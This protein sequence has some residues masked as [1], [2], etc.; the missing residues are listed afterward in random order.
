MKHLFLLI[1]FII[2]VACGAEQPVAV[3]CDTAACQSAEF[4]TLG[5]PNAP[6][7]LIE[8][9]DYQC[10]FCERHALETFP[11][12]KSEL[13]DTGRIRYQL[14]D[15]PI[16]ALHPLA[17]RQHAAARCVGAAGGTEAYWT[18]HDLFFAEKVRFAVADL[19]A[20][21]DVILDAFAA[22]DLPN[23]SD[24]LTSGQ[25]AADVQAD[26]ALGLA[27]EV[28]ATPTFEIDGYTFSG[29]QPFRVFV[30]LVDAAENGQLADAF[31][32]TP[33]PAVVAPTPAAIEPRPN[34]ALGDPNAPVTIIE[35]SDFQCPFCQR[36]ALETFPQMQQMIDDG[37]LYYVYK[38]Y[39]I[40]ALHP[41]A[42]RL[43]E[44]A[45]CVRDGLGTAA[46]WQTH[47]LFFVNAETFAVEDVMAL[48]E[49]ISAELTNANLWTPDVQSCIDER[50]TSAEVAAN[51]REG[52]LLG[53]TDTPTFFVQGYPVVGAQPFTAFVYAVELAEQGD[54]L[55]LFQQQQGDGE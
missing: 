12:I 2:L 6:I 42:H 52:E 33:A 49:V 41:L 10:P 7:T 37:R 24:C 50:A 26:F 38:D 11:L 15:F 34:T 27:A 32:P 35:Y 40:A 29:A 16:D 14:R 20:L 18:A 8:Y 45:L 53:I 9:T 22:A 48:G 1:A 19:A 13:I 21:D 17:Y 43:H 54:L 55:E 44:A 31:E 23:V 28:D 25:F 4:M 51:I 5:D 30:Q 46:F 47:D 36:H 39:P 3:V